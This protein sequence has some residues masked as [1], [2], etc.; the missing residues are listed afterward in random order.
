MLNK[1]VLI[2]RLTKDP[3]LEYT[4]SGLAVTKFILAVDRGFT[5]QDGEKKADF[6][7]IVVWRAQA[8]AS[9]KYL[10]KGRLV[11]VAGRIQTGHYEADDGTRRYTT[12]VVADDVR[13]LEWGEK[14]QAQ[15]D[16]RDVPGFNPTNIPDDE[17]P[18]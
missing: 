6:V 10:T 4:Q 16:N 11:A 13:F 17:L 1:V 12:D 18:F 5:G 15:Q 14:G 8:E 9:A 7:P 2:G 3:D